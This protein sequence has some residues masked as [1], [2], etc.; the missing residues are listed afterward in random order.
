MLKNLHIKNYALIEDINLSVTEGLNIITGETGAGKSILLGAL[1]LLT[2][3]R[4]DVSAVRKGEKKCVIEGEFGIKNYG[5]AGFFQAN[6]L[7]FDESTIIRREVAA[8]GKSR[9]FIN[10]TPV[11]L[12]L[13]KS[14]GEVLI[15]IH[16]QQDN[17]HLKSALFF[18]ALLDNYG[19]QIKE[20]LAYAKSFADFKKLQNQLAVLL[21]E[22]EKEKLNKDFNLFQLKELEAANLKENEQED[23]E[24]EFEVLNNS[25][26]L[27]E[28]GS[29]VVNAI[30]YDNDSVNDRLSEVHQAL[31]KLSKIS[32]DYSEMSNRI[33]SAIIDVKDIA[34][35]VGSRLNNISGDANRVVEIDE[36]LALFFALQKKHNL[37]SNE[38]LIERRDKLKALVSLAD[39]D[40]SEINDLKAR[41]TALEQTLK[42]QAE[43]LSEVRK[44]AAIAI[45][46]EVCA[47]LKRMGINQPQIQFK[48]EESDLNANGCNSIEVLFSANKG[49]DLGN[50]TKSASGG[51]LSRVM[52]SFKKI[53]SSKKSLPTI[54]FDEIDTGVSGE[55]ADQMGMIMKQMGSSMQVISITH[56]PQIAAKG[57]SHFMVY[58][59]H[60]AEQTSSQIKLLS[61]EERINEVAQMLSGAKVTE[62]SKQNAIELLG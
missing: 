8:N 59:N 45:E 10:D 14:I 30:L 42:K 36:R 33:N 40:S 57:H 6:D 5:L 35:E 61:K 29:V 22:Q 13:L 46:K 60:D 16:S 47:D 58:K 9:A 12:N 39:E 43:G 28:L 50:I 24:R 52:L 51:E 19:G 2:G 41:I 7:D 18:Y 49:T 34:E 56:L 54:L 38:Q 11:N 1:G 27:K 32:D 15:D 37:A 20:T 23:L 44:N 4:A 62:A 3:K 53:L 48:L 31:I 55:V 17:Q 25:E 21:E 26:E